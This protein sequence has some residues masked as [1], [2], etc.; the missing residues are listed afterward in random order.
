M[1]ATALITAEA[2]SVRLADHIEYPPSGILSKE[3]WKRDRC[4]YSLFC[5]AAGTEISEHTSTR[6]AT[7][8]VLEGSGKFVLQGDDIALE[9]GVF[10]AIPANAPHALQA[11]TNLAFVLTL[12]AV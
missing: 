2:A 10:V 5:L 11:T 6:D 4:Q 3:I 8:Q 9:P 1:M 12:V 7:V